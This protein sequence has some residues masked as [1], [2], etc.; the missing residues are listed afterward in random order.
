MGTTCQLAEEPQ[1][2]FFSPKTRSTAGKKRHM[3]AKARRQ[4]SEVGIFLERW[5]IKDLE[6]DKWIILS[7]D[8]QRRNSNALQVAICAGVSIVIK[9]VA[10]TKSGSRV[11]VVEVDEC[12]D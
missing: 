5:M 10:V 7:V 1:R 8:H 9:G 3:P 11:G 6:W 2:L 12:S 4:Q